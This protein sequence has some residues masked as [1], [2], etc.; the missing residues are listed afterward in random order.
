MIEF[1]P[2]EETDRRAIVDL[3]KLAFPV[4]AGRLEEAVARLRLE[5]Y[6]GAYEDGRLVAT[7]QAHP[8]Q[9]WFGGRPLPCAGIASVTAAPERRGMGIVSSLM[10]E[11]LV[12]ER[13]RGVPLSALYPATVPVYR[14]LGY[15][16]AGTYTEYSAKLRSLPPSAAGAVE[17]FD[18]EDPEPLRQCFTRF[19]ANQNGI[20][21]CDADDWWPTRVLRR[22][23]PETVSHAV[24]ARGS[25]GIDGYAAFTR[26]DLQEN[27][28]FRLACTHLVANTRAAL[29][30][31]L[32][33]F[34]RFQGIGHEVK[35]QGPP[36]E[37]TALLLTEQS[38]E[39]T[40]T[41]R[42]MLR[43]LDVRAALEGRGYPEVDG[44][45]T[46]GVADDLFPANAATYELT[47]EGG[48]VR[49]ESVDRQARTVL[50]I[51]IL[52]A[53]YSGYL[54]SGDLVRLGHIDGSDPA[55]PLLARLFAGP[56]PWMPDFF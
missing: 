11:V 37:P 28:G 20:V 21:D 30:S 1:R 52:S 13:E 19:A 9:Q 47:A 55:V 50:P 42:F 36:N 12:R 49:A 29:E 56:P 18:Q 3:A 40:F 24:V 4:P 15:E 32:G 43:I 41:F 54:T 44:Q 46:L 7:V 10:R 22:V 2:P 16:Y 38:L 35:W 6:L 8:F 14:R 27:F 45:G 39:T 31:L 17:P 25:G 53:L 5:R 33:Y 48:K 34:R 51:G 23:G 26:E